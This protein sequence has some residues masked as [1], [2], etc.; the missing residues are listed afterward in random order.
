M[1]VPPNEPLTDEQ[2]DR[3]ETYL[4]AHAPAGVNIEWVDGFF[5]ALICGPDMVMPSEYLPRVLGEEFDFDDSEQAGDIM[6]L[7]MQH[8]NTIAGELLRTVSEPHVYLPVLLE[9]A[10]GVAHANDWAK[11]FMCGVQMRPESWRE[12][13]Y[14]EE[15]GGS[16]IPIM[17]LAHEDDPDPSMRPP[18]MDHEKRQEVITMMIAGLT[19]IY[20]H[21]EQ[22]RRSPAR[23]SGA[24]Q[25][26]R[27]GRKV[28]R[29]EPCP[30][31]SGRKYKHC[32]ANSLH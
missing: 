30:C 20:R 5:A 1:L 32:C 27:E 4:D 28:G 10:D 24:V 29:N 22:Q 14:S 2:F 23:A 3:L 25:R 11:G 16:A 7:L 18:P 12:L 9:D 6:G 26:R 31:G 19:T 15:R 8:W 21:F 13:L 17:M